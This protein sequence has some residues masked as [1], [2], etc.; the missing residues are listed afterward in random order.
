MS[1]LFCWLAPHVKT[2]RCPGC[3]AMASLRAQASG[4]WLQAAYP[5]PLPPR[6]CARTCTYE[7]TLHISLSLYIY[8]YM[9]THNIF[10]YI[11]IYI[12][13]YIHTYITQSRDL[14]MRTARTKTEKHAQIRTTHLWKTR[15]LAT[16]SRSVISTLKQ[17]T[18]GACKYQSYI[19]KGIWRQGIGY[20]A[21]NSY[22][23]TLCAVVICPYLCTHEM[24]LRIAISTLAYVIDLLG[25]RNTNPQQLYLR[26]R[27]T[28][29]YVPVQRHFI[30]DITLYYYFYY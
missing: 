27:A 16:I 26:A 25:H 28:A 20:F 14:Q 6:T 15:G 4:C 11:Y 8:I 3:V 17:N 12:H 29:S 1:L 30:N 22:V 24:K 21:R 9:Y 2:R 7:H 5:L 23:S 10:V 19:S 18:Q 13:T